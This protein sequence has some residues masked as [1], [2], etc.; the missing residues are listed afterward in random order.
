MGINQKTGQTRYCRLAVES[1]VDGNLT[2]FNVGLG[3]F[4]V[5]WR[6]VGGSRVLNLVIREVAGV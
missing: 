1:G 4:M 5:C 2:A 3:H 6:F